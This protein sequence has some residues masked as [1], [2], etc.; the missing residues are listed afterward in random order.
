MYTNV[1]NEEKF[2]KSIESVV[3]NQS[4]QMAQ[5]G[6]QSD[7]F[8]LKDGGDVT[9]YSVSKQSKLPLSQSLL[10]SIKQQKMV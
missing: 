2:Q 6:L 1:G 9:P 3:K 5:D 8:L 7:F 10:K 4:S